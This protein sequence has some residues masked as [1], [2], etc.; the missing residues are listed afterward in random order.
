MKKKLLTT[1]LLALSCG[2]AIAGFACNKGDG[3]LAGTDF[4]V[5]FVDGAGYSFDGEGYQAFLQDDD[6]KLAYG[7]TLSFEV[8]V[9]AFYTGTP[10]VYCNET[11]LQPILGVYTATVSGDTVIRV[12]GVRKDVSNMQG[13]GSYEDAFVVTKPIDLLYI[14]EQVNKGVSQYVNGSYILANDI[15]CKGEELQVIGNHQT[16]KAY[17]AGC[18]PRLP[19]TA[20]ALRN[21]PF[22]TSSSTRPTSITLVFSDTYIAT[23]R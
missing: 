7:D 10:I 5:S 20:K 15:D 11:P 6:K 1:M 9:G 16:D 22:P 3:S 8:E 18:F 12:E 21:T 13:S 17:F 14:A 2:C 4:S 19:P 23:R